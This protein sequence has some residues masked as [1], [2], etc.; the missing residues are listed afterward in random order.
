L[1][2]KYASVI[3]SGYEKWEVQNINGL[4]EFNSTR[5]YRT[6]LTAVNN[7]VD[8]LSKFV[9]GSIPLEITRQQS[10]ADTGAADT[11]FDNDTFIIV[12]DRINYGFQVEQG[13]IDNPANIFS[14][15]TVINWRIR[16]YY[17]LMR[18]FKS[19]ANSYPNIDDTINKLYFSSGTGNYVAEG[20]LIQGLYDVDCK[21][22]NGVKAE[23][24]NLSKL[25]FIDTAEATP[26][27]K[28]ETASF[29]YPLSVKDYQLLKAN[30]YG[31]ISFQPGKGDFL[32]GFI[33]SV[34]YKVNEGTA[35]FVLKLKWE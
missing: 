31:Y 1:E 15:G 29:T 25:D 33:Q 10:F 21:L 19:L 24:R 28:P 22:E 7:T 8:L 13:N 12:L 6:G 17:N 20:E 11:K 32:K 30:P 18:W 26:L 23:N 3:R 2:N 16:P 35:D 5:E 14:P 4:E 27:W 9:A 34:K